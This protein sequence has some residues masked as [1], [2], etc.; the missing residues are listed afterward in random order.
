MLQHF[1]TSERHFWGFDITLSQDLTERVS[2]DGSGS[3]HIIR[4]Q[5]SIKRYFQKF[6][7]YQQPDLIHIATGVFKET[8]LSSD[9]KTISFLHLAGGELAWESL[10][11]FYPK[12]VPG[13]YIFVSG[14]YNSSSGLGGGGCTAMQAVEKYRAAHHIEDP[15]VRVVEQSQQ[16]DGGTHVNSYEEAFWWKKS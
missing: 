6:D 8:V 5:E 14:S 10:L 11:H 12:V 7:A 3:K 9:V 4:T 15:L 13:G 1:N 16:Q 2:E